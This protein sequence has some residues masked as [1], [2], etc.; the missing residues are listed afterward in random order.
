MLPRGVD[1]FLVV[2]GGGSKDG[3]RSKPEKFWGAMPTSG[4]YTHFWPVLSI[5]G[6]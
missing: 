2:G 5:N 4:Q 1:N 3:K 6:K